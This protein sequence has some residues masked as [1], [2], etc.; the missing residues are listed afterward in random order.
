MNGRGLRVGLHVGQL[1]Q[2]VPGGIGRYVERLVEHLPAAGLNVVPFSAGRPVPSLPGHVDLGWPRGSRRYELWHRLRRPRLRLDVDVVHATSLA[3]PPPGPRPLVVTVHD[4]AFLERA[5]YHTPRGR[6]F[7]RRGLE[8]TRREAAVVL[9]PSEF[10]GDELTRHGIEPDRIVV[11]RHGV[12][13]PAEVG[14]GEVDQTLRALGV[15]EPFLL[16]VGAAETRKGTD[17]LLTAFTLARAR[18]PDLDLVLVSP[19]GWGRLAPVPGARALGGVTDAELDALYRRATA[20]VYPS[21]HE[22]F[23]MPLLEAMARGCPVV[24]TTVSALP[25]V[26]GD[27]A[28]LVDPGDT[29]ALADAVS[30][31]LDDA[32][33]RRRLTEAGPARARRF[34]WAASAE[35]HAD[36]YRLAAER[37]T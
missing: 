10:V 1:L 7:H 28:L 30:S 23:G 26:A 3:V 21:R 19:G 25:E 5:E 12:D 31:V 6:R 35:A 11:A 20:L 2:P 33:V 24:T 16:H 9:V 18:H 32:E 22:G 27:A 8:L 13:P 36:A 17:T 14:V 29:S 4:V 37:A 34:S 15:E